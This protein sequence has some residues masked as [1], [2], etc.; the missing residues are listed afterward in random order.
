MRIIKKI[1]MD[2]ARQGLPAYVDGVRGDSATWL[3]FTLLSSGK[4]WEIP[5]EAAAMVRFRLPAG[6]G[7]EYDTVDGAKAWEK[8]ENIL[9]VLLAPAVC[10]APGET[11][12]QV[13]LLLGGKQIS[14]FPVTL[15][16]APTVS[17]SGTPENY[18][19]LAQWLKFNIGNESIN[20]GEIEER[21]EALETA[22]ATHVT[23]EDVRQMIGDDP[24]G[25]AIYA[26]EMED[27]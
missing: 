6:T 22:S 4:P 23:A 18:T 2:L 25:T 11:Q 9:R 5:V 15:E 19:N 24:W 21:L 14:T 13:V 8:E 26:G 20:L 27:V 16:V 3:E 17:G 7:G 12:L 1:T 10:S